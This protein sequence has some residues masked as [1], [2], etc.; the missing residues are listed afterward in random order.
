VYLIAVS[1][2][3]YVFSVEEGGPIPIHTFRTYLTN[4]VKFD[5]NVNLLMELKPY[6]LKADSS[7]P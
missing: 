5:K 6:L 7:K 2:D 3:T 4:R 1:V